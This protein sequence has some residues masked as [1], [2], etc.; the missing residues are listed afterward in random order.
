ME[1]E[2]NKWSGGG[3]NFKGY[4]QILSRLEYLGI[5][6]NNIGFSDAHYEFLVIKKLIELEP[7]HNL[8]EVYWN[9]VKGNKRQ[10]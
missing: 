1:E 10:E 3:S 7:D 6:K 8:R 9:M 5:E 2:K 4:N